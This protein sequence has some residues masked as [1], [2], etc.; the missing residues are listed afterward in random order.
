MVF[1]PYG[2]KSYLLLLGGNIFSPGR[3]VILCYENWEISCF[4]RK[5]ILYTAALIAPRCVSITT[6]KDFTLLF[7]HKQLST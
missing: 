7:T 4:S 5:L 2:F 6:H 3:Y 1:F